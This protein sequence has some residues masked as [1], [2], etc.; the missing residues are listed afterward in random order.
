MKPWMWLVVAAIGW[1]M[2]LTGYM[3]RAR[4]NPNAPWSS[5]AIV[6]GPVRT[7]EKNGA[8]AGDDI[9][10]GPT[11][12]AGEIAAKEAEFPARSPFA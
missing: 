6:I 4:I 2:M 9:A 10:N 5:G 3:L 11:A 7:D 1:A 8:K 12:K